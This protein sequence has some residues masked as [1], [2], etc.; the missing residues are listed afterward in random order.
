[1]MPLTMLGAGE[2]AA[3]KRIGGRDESKTYLENL[4]YT[5]G[6]RIRVVSSNN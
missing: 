5:L 2:D 6:D 3:I 4:G 1:M